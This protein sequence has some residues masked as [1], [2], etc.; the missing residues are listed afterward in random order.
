MVSGHTS[1][2]S[3]TSE[4]EMEDQ[5]IQKLLIVTQT[6]PCHKKQHPQGDRTGNFTSRSKLSSDIVH[7]INDGLYF[8]EKV[9]RCVCACVC[10]CVCVCVYVCV[11]GACVCVYVVD[12]YYDRSTGHA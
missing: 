9:R 7:V 2:R 8:Y 4:D 10:V 6:P 1:L 12:W 11:H 5:D 3:D